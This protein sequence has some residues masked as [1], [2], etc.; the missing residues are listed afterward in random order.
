MAE[1]RPVPPPRPAATSSSANTAPP[2]AAARQRLLTRHSTP[3]THSPARTPFDPHRRR[4]SLFSADSLDDGSQ[5]LLDEIINPR[6]GRRHAQQ[7]S[8]AVTH[9]HSS[10]IA[11][12]ILPALGG[13]LFKNGSNVI[14]DAL[15]LLLAAV[16]MN[17]SIQLPWDWYYAAQALRPDTEPDDDTI[18]EE[19]DDDD[20]AVETSSSTEGL[21]QQPAADSKQEATKAPSTRKREQ[22]ATSLH[23]QELL[24]LLALFL[25]PA[26]AAYLLHLIRAQLSRRATTL[27][28]DFN[29]SIFLLAAEVRPIVQLI[30]L[31][32]ARTIHL[33]RSVSG[34]DDPLAAAIHDQRTPN[35][36]TTRIAEL[37]ARFSADLASPSPANTTSTTLQKP[38]IETLSA[39]LR[40]RYEP[41]LEGL[42]RAVRRYEKRSTTLSLLTDQRLL[43]LE[44][45][46]QDALSLAAVAAQHSQRR[47]LVAWALETTS[48]LIAVPMRLVWG[49]CVWPWLMAE[50]L[51]AG[52]KK[53]MLGPYGVVGERGERG[54]RGGSGRSREGGGSGRSREGGVD[55]KGRVRGS[56]RRAGGR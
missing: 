8:H 42:E 14:T 6:T 11:L 19:A 17:W 18:Y 1:A 39:D 21:P 12:A 30:R 20:I 55:E 53:V 33:H 4:S 50:E 24:A 54:S 22:A 16:F 28:S 32:S 7:D 9:W 56:S 29:L 3:Q 46:L 26:L 34:I 44:T 10:P 13:L 48:T 43:S 5:S 15:L 45:R 49:V 25:F 38:D 2:P 51:G 35:S 41:R 36:L 23:Q 27:V 31:V 52:V 47:G 37:E 40:K